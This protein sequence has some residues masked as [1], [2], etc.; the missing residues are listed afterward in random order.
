[1]ELVNT[2]KRIFSVIL[3]RAKVRPDFV[4]NLYVP[5]KKFLVAHLSISNLKLELPKFEI[6]Y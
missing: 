4:E 2:T 6:K 5:S 1:M 3:P